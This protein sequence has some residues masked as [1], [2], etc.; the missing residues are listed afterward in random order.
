VTQTS[1]REEAVL[2]RAWRHE[3]RRIFS[4]SRFVESA[5]KEGGNKKNQMRKRLTMGLL[6]G[7]KEEHF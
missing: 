3:Q 7:A 5:S 6:H 2:Q 4:V 1:F